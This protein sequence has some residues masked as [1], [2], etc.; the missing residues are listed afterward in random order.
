MNRNIIKENEPKLTPDEGT[1]KKFKSNGVTYE[2]GLSGNLLLWRKINDD[3]WFESS[4]TM[5][6]EN[7][8]KLKQ[9]FYN[10]NPGD[11]IYSKKKV[12]HN[13]KKQ[14]NI[15]VDDKISTA[16]PEVETQQTT[17]T[18]INTSNQFTDYENEFVDGNF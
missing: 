4:D 13:N 5:K 16:D 11:S 15:K 8:I 18:T 3:Q 7:I 9:R 17:T 14:K 2:L 10:L 12:K 6:T 1:I